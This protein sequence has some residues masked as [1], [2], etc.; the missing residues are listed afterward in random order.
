MKKLNLV[1]L[2]LLIIVGGCLRL[3]FLDQ[4]PPSPNWDE[5]SLGYNAYSILLTGHDEWGV[6]LP[7]IFRA[8]GDYKLPGFIYLLTPLIQILGLSTF[9]IRLLSGVSGLFNIF[10]IFFI[11][12]HFT[13]KYWIAILS[14]FIMCVSP[15]SFF[16][17]RVALEANLGLFLFLLG[18]SLLIS[19]RLLPAILF[20]GLSAW[21]Y[22]SFRIFTP[23]FI[24]LYSV[25]NYHKIKISILHY[26]L[27]I[28]LFIPIFIQLLS[29][30]GQARFYWTTVLDSGAIARINE[31]RSRPGG[32]LVYNKVTYFTVVFA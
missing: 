1:I 15:W 7:T 4:F 22:N 19:K 23:L 9:S 12:H 8:F 29:S 11:S 16:V 6:R 32:R 17:S 28:I 18:L 2:F 27:F 26:S 3:F 24:I 31:L 20:L 10:L 14:A 25:F 30:S 5:V 21:T 13:K